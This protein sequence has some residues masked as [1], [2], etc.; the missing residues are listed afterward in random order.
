MSPDEVSNM[1]SLLKN[2]ELPPK[3]QNSSPSKTISLTLIILNK[4]NG[5]IAFL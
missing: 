5:I 3:V 1:L 4:V 2:H